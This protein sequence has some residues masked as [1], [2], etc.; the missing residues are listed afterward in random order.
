MIL[1]ATSGSVLSVNQLPTSQLI[2]NLQKRFESET[3]LKL[4]GGDVGAVSSASDCGETI[5]GEGFHFEQHWATTDDGYILGMYRIPP[6][7]SSGVAPV[8]FLQHG[9]V[10]SCWCWIANNRS[11]SLAF[12]FADAG[13]DVWLGNSR[14]NTYRYD[15]IKGD[16]TCPFYC[17]SVSRV[18]AIHYFLNQD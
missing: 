10:D 12:M 7:S 3:D 9:V 18:C 17:D 16:S 8:V 15:L 13:F 14:G 4:R 5:A 11:N 2:E 6:T 1:A